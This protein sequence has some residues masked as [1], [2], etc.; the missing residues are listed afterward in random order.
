[1]PTAMR[2]ELATARALGRRYWLDLVDARALPASFVNGLVEYTA[3]RAVAA[4]FQGEN[5]P[6]GYAMLEARGFGGFVPWFIRVRALPEMVGEPFANP[7]DSP[8]RCLLMLNK[9]DRWLI[10]PVV[11]VAIGWFIRSGREGHVSIE[12]FE[13]VLY[14]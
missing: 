5:N 12:H 3:R 2:P 8:A 7:A 6:P 10:H 9:L 11:V 1:P 13:D 4:T 14:V